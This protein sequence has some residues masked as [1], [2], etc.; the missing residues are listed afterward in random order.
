MAGL[1]QQ[2]M[3]GCVVARVDS[4]TDDAGFLVSPEAARDRLAMGHAPQLQAEAGEQG[5]WR[6]EADLAHAH[7]VVGWIAGFTAGEGLRMHVRIAAW[8]RRKSVGR[9]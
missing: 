2:R 9:E 5:S 1:M 3:H 7:D 8:G 4:A 6:I